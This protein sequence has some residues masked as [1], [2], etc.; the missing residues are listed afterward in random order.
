M[1]DEKF[2]KLPKA[3]WKPFG[4]GMRACIGRPF[5][6]QE[7]L[8]VTAMLLQNFNFQLDDPNY[9]LHIKQ[10]LTIKPKDFYMRATLRDGVDPAHLDKSQP[11][12]RTSGKADKK[13]AV[14]KTDGE[15]DKPKK[16]MSVFFGSNTGTC[17]SLAQKLATNAAAHGFDAVVA[18]LDSATQRLPKGHP[19]VIIT[20]SYEGLPPDNAAHFTEW[21]KSLSK[22]EAKECSFAVFGCGHKDWAATYQRVPV[23]IDEL[24]AAR[25]GTK[26]TER[27]SADASQGD[28]FNEFDSWEDDN[29]WPSI[30]SLFGGITTGEAPEPTVQV[31]ISTQKRSSNLRSDVRGARILE[32]AVLTSPGTPEKRHLKIQLPT[33]MAYR[34]GDYLAVLPVNPPENIRRVMKRFQLPWD[35]TLTISSG[36]P[37]VLPTDRPISAHDVLAAYVELGQPTTRKN[38][39]TLSTLSPDVETK[40]HLEQLASAEV[41]T[42]E[43]TRK[44]VSPL[45]LLE[46][47][48]TLPI[49]LGDFLS[50]LPPMRV[51]QYSISSSPLPDPQVCTVTYS[52]LDQD[53]FSGQG[54]HVGV[55][56][57]YLSTLQE[58]DYTQ[59][60]V[61]SSAQPFHLPLDPSGAPVIMV[62]AGTGIAP[63]RGFVEERAEQIKAG[64]RLAR[65]LL[66]VGCRDPARDRLYAEEF[67]EWEKLGAVELR[68]AFSRKEVESEGCKYVQDRMLHDWKDVVELWD[69]GAKVYVCGNSVVGDEVG[70]ACKEMYRRKVK[71]KGLKEKGDDEVEE[72]FAGVRSER[73]ATDVF[74]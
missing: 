63:F 66:F 61:R 45:D 37:T 54:R 4:N 20:A 10:S 64:R 29:L 71:E 33:G 50:M 51:R 21:L 42:E 14:K 11:K 46:R 28:M 49:A 7:A 48:P 2:N 73:F 3:A 18:P 17:E 32:S 15:T 8:L 19:S 40:S 30:T 9:E 38:L 26:L 60:S 59:V 47:Y 24:L 12:S 52:V 72:W 27:G 69:A 25:G 55:A 53:A 34:A 70:K 68:Y 1:L 22:D 13:V 67:K 74:A 41:F 62:C 65:A 6:W 16:P 57:N 44:R 31:E 58:G 23:L 36:A 5:A 43:I 35:A 39:L 56:S